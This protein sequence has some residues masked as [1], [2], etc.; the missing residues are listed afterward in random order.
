M[1]DDG[2]IL[3]DDGVLLCLFSPLQM[4]E[5]LQLHIGRGGSILCQD[6]S[7]FITHC[8]KVARTESTVV[9][10]IINYLLENGSELSDNKSSDVSFVI[11]ELKMLYM[12]N[13]Y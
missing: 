8:I 2:T 12:Y 5:R 11:V 13:D 10:L 4:L 1:P 7:S 3:S 9:K 6:I